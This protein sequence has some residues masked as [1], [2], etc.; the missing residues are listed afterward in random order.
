MKLVPVHKEP[1]AERILYRLRLERSKEDDPFLPWADRQAP[2]RKEFRKE[3]KSAPY[4]R[5]LL[6]K[7]RRAYVGV[8]LILKNNEIGIILFQKYRSRG[9][10]AQAVAML[11]ESE[12][13]IPKV[14]PG[15]FR[16][17]IHPH[18]FRSIKLFERLGF[19]HAYNLYELQK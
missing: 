3:F 13:P 4:H 7:V 8:V 2:T 18:N 19:Q 11:L 17:R 15:R 1:R 9:Y 10:G 6:V 16:A 5:W 14:A 12:S